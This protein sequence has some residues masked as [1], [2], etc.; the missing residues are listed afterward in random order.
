MRII[1]KSDYKVVDQLNQTPSK[2][3]IL[4]LL[5]CSEAHRY[6]LVKFLR[7]THVPHEISVCRFEGVVNN[8]ASSISLGFSDDELPPEG[9]KYNKAL[10][11]S[12]ERVNTILSRVLVDTGS[13]LNVL[14]KSFF[15]I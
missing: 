3:L 5:M 2:I 4:S 10:H 1:K 7:T 8:I 15:F 9:R 6:T 13:S 12:I 14:P 11:I